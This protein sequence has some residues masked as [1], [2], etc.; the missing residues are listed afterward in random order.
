MAP[1]PDPTVTVTLQIL[2]Q[3]DRNKM[4]VN[5]FFPA[6]RRLKKDLTLTEQSVLLRRTLCVV[7]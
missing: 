4:L 7:E 5:L 2:G 6:V 1:L 3:T